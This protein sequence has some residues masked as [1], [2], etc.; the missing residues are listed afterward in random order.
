MTATEAEAE[1]EA[2]RPVESAWATQGEPF[3]ETERR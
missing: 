2:E 1:A 3:S